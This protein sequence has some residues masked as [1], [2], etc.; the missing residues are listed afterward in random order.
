[1]ALVVV[2][3]LLLVGTAQWF[4][5]ASGEASGAAQESIGSI[6]SGGPPQQVPVTDK[7]RAD[8]QELAK[9][10]LALNL[11]ESINATAKSALDGTLG[12]GRGGRSGGSGGGRGTTTSMVSPYLAPPVSPE[13]MD[14][15]VSVL[16]A[17][18][19]TREQKSHALRKL[20]VVGTPEIVPVVAALL[21]D[22]ELSHMARFALEPIPDPSVDRAFRDALGK[23]QGRPLLGVIG[24]IGVRRDAQAVGI[25]AGLLRNSDPEVVHAAALALGRIGN[26]EAA[27]ALESAAAGAPGANLPVL[28]EGL[29]RCAESLS[30]QGQA[31]SA[32]AIYDQL[33]KPDAATAVRTAA[34]RGAILARKADGVKLLRQHL[35][36]SD[37]DMFVAAVQTAQ[38]M[39]AA[40]TTQALTDALAALSKDEDKILVIGTLGKRGDVAAVPVLLPLAQ[41]GSSR[42]RLAAIE[43]LPQLPQ[44]AS[45]P[46]LVSLMKDPDA[47]IAAAATASLA[48]IP[49]KEADA[50]ALAMLASSQ[51]NE[52]ITGIE[53]AASRGIRNS[54]ADLL[55]MAGSHPDAK[56]RRAALKAAGSIAGAD[57]LPA[58]IELAVNAKS[59]E[60]LDS[61]VSAARSTLA[62]V[63]DKTGFTQALLKRL[64][65]AQP[66]QKGALF[67]LF[68]INPGPEALGAVQ[69]AVSDPDWQVHVAALQ[70][71]ADWPDFTAVKPLIDIAANPSTNLTDS[72][73]ALKGSARII[74]NS[75]SAPMNER[76]ALC[77]TAYD[78]VRRDEERRELIS[79]M[80]ALRSPEMGEK[81]LEIAA[82]NQTLRT[83]AGTAAG[84]VVTSLYTG[85]L[86]GGRGG[87]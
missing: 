23:V 32:I 18:D 83:E 12:G 70:T 3:V 47:T 26:A 86:G 51:P 45:V 57:H 20:S 80:G 27:K 42:V 64:G 4:A 46:V 84:Q 10:L 66:A 34:L 30:S 28:S 22:P 59:P 8:A 79:V 71:L 77:K 49:G 74:R 35:Q 38:E 33:L 65:Q 44:A 73:L 39:T 54:V 78:S 56:V 52:L 60:D 29:F 48:T 19:S 58:L 63:E 72:V 75:Y 21:G 5:Y 24:S 50:A 55:K 11:S 37:P 16:K 1:L 53:M 7:D 76:V 62:N 41:A 15:L 87:R 13:T 81:L 43:A 9:K 68:S 2:A 17:P 67:R 82:K 69:A 14:Q 36:G 6:R 61:A 85:R 25:L 40:G 31:A